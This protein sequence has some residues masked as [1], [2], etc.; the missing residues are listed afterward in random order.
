MG[1]SV[2]VSS[3]SAA[4]PAVPSEDD[5]WEQVRLLRDENTVLKASLAR[6]T[7]AAAAEEGAG[8]GGGGGDSSWGG[9][10]GGGL[11]QVSVGRLLTNQI[12]VVVA[13]AEATVACISADAGAEDVRTSR[14]E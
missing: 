13:Y 7:A 12:P 14:I 1:V 5:A 9:G 6:L 2:G 11:Q 3:S 10:R 8:G 4:A